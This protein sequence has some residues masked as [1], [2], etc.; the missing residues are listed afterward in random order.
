MRPREDGVV[1]LIALLAVSTMAAFTAIG[2]TRSTTD[3]RA[4]T[5]SMTQQQA[6]YVAEAGKS[7]LPAQRIAPGRWQPA[8]RGKGCGSSAQKTMQGRSTPNRS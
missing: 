3:L 2:L 5:F 8:L 1:L 4:A 7:E 6:L